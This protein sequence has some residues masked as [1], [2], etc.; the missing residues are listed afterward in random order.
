MRQTQKP[1]DAP[2]EPAPTPGVRP[3]AMQWAAMVAAAAVVAAGVLAF[4]WPA[5]AVLALFYLENVVIGVG[6]YFRLLLIGL[7]LPLRAVLTTVGAL[8]F[9]PV[10]YGLFC[11]G[12]A[13]I[14]VAIFGGGEALPSFAPAPVQLLS[15][16]LAESLG[17]AALAAM[18]ITV[19]L[20]GVRWWRCR[21]GPFSEE[22]LVRQMFAPYPRIV[23]LH[24]TIMVGGLLLAASAAP[25]PMVLALVAL[26]LA[27]DAYAARRPA[28]FL[29]GG[30]DP[31]RIE[32]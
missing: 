5:Y 2:Q 10:H 23:I 26:K 8:A 29:F 16:A 3:T 19:A 27:F 13:E 20:D 12:H 18:A 9:F 31:A 22:A 4:D 28:G 30:A 1:I 32:S 7:R 21:F 15:H 17:W 14:L 25:E 11:F 6:T 24:V